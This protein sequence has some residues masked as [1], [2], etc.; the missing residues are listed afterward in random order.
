[1]LEPTW[2]LGVDGTGQLGR[3][4]VGHKQFW[5]FPSLRPLNKASLLLRQS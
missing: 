5:S 1:M 2:H 4:L 3:N